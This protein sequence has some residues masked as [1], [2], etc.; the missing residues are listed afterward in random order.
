M[1]IEVSNNVA[2]LPGPP[3]VTVTLRRS[4]QVRRLNLRVSGLDGQVTLSMPRDL[5]Q[6]TALQFLIEKEGWLRKA[7]ARIPDQR[8]VMPGQEIL[9]RGTPVRISACPDLRRVLERD[10]ALLVPQDASETRTTA[11]LAGYLKASA[12][13]ELL[14]AAQHYAARLGRP[15]TAVTLRDTRSRW[16]SCTSQG[17][18]MFSWRLIMAPPEVL[19]YVAAHEVA[20][21]RHMDHSR[22][23]WGC[24]G[25]LMPD[26][27]AHRAWLRNHGAMLHSYAFDPSA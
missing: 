27:A 4:T 22:A 10:G 23:F 19:R 24:V 18:L 13:V 20:H 7:L 14:A 26:Y 12:R 9:L 3:P 21:L 6:Y 16:G 2:T 8:R 1:E 11:R 25:D 5:P 17:R 15:I